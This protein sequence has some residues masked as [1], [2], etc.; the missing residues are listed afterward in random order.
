MWLLVCWAH[1]SAAASTQVV[2]SPSVQH[3]LPRLLLEDPQP[4]VR[5][6]AC[7][8]LYRLCLGGGNASSNSS[9]VLNMAHHVVPAILQQLLEH[10]PRAEGMRLCKIEVCLVFLSYVCTCDRLDYVY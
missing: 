3:W 9:S 7:S 5:R 4:Q 1:S 2:C 8:A 6:E 10:L